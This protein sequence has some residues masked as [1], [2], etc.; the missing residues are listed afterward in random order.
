MPDGTPSHAGALCSPGAYRVLPYRAWP[1]ATGS[2][3]RDCEALPSSPPQS[4]PPPASPHR[5][6]GLSATAA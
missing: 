6:E 4:P 1:E 5:H 2:Q 3:P